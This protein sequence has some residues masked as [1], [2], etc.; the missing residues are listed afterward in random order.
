M[1]KAI[2]ISQLSK[3]YRLGTN[4]GYDTLRDS[5]AKFSFR[6][7]LDKSEFW[8]LDN[9]NLTVNS[10]EVIGIIGPNGSGKST[11]LKILSR[12]TPPTKGEIRI[13]G[14]IASLLEVGTG[15]H[16]ELTG[17]ENIYLNGAILG[18]T[19]REI[20]QKFESI[21]DFSGIGKFID[22]PIKHYSSG[23]LVRLAFSVAAFLDTNILLVDE[24]LA[25]GDASF[26]QMSIKKMGEL[27]KK[28]GKTILYVSHNLGSVSA[29]CNRA[30]YLNNGHLV[31]QGKTDKI[32]SQYL[33][34]TLKGEDLKRAFSG[35]LSDVITIKSI[36]L[37]RFSSHLVTV[38]PGQDLHFLVEG[39][40]TQDIKNFRFTFSIYTDDIRLFSV[41]DVSGYNTTLKAGKFITELIIRNHNLRPGRYHLAFGG[42]N[43][44][45]SSFVWGTNLMTFMVSD[46]WSENNEQINLGVINLRNYETKRVN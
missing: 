44:G 43:K 21:V 34:A 32:I 7:V 6:R 4:I 3:K 42:H 17:R 29:L 10:G 28:E 39:R 45:S 35:N 41:H 18:M 15:F 16:Q 14:R 20:K 30:I 46:Q 1:E 26:Q 27:T 33:S 25:V 24:V 8:A 37:N 11:L 9:I 13:N 23:M 22:T 5:I 31:N 40:S 38:D 19:R 2:I 36:S 12:I